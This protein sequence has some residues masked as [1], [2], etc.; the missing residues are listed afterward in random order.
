[1]IY[2]KFD[3]RTARAIKKRKLLLA[4]ANKRPP[5]SYQNRRRFSFLWSVVAAPIL[6]PPEHSMFLGCTQEARRADCHVAGVLFNHQHAD[7]ISSSRFQGT[8]CSHER[9]WDLY[10]NLDRQHRSSCRVHQRPFGESY[11]KYANLIHPTSTARELKL[12]Q[13]RL[14]RYHRTSKLAL[15]SMLEMSRSRT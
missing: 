1:M 8:E 5:L 2:E 15:C 9:G 3:T 7:Q 10:V 13:A 12:T 11:N 6:S 4:H 14:P